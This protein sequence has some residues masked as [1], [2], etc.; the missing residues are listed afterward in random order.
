MILFQCDHRGC[1]VQ[2]KCLGVWY[3]DRSGRDIVQPPG[4]WLMMTDG[5]VY[6]SKHS[7][8]ER[9][10]QRHDEDPD[11]R[12]CEIKPC[13]HHALPDVIFCRLHNDLFEVWQSKGKNRSASVD[14][15]CKQHGGMRDS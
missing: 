5:K 12:E 11:R 1:K 6:C 4:D 9:Q 14:D 10:D 3:D 2:R 15:F 13:K 7:T 8:E